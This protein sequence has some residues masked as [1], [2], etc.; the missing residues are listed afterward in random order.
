MISFDATK[1]T[2]NVVSMLGPKPLPKTKYTATMLT[3]NQMVILGGVTTKETVPPFT[4][5]FLPLMDLL[6]FDTNIATW[7]PTNGTG[8]IPADRYSHVAVLGTDGISIIVC[9][10]R[11]SAEETLNDV[12]VLNTQN[13]TWTKPAVVGTPP[14]GRGGLS[15]VFNNGQMII[16]FGIDGNNTEVNEVNVLDTR[17]TPFQW[18]T[19]FSPNASDFSSTTFP[20]NYNSTDT[21]LNNA[22]ASDFAPSDK[23]KA[24]GGFPGVI[25]IGISVLLIVGVIITFLIVRKPWRKR[26]Q[27]K[28]VQDFKNVL[29][30]IP[31]LDSVNMRHIKSSDPYKGRESSGM[32]PIK[33]LPYNSDCQAIQGVNANYQLPQAVPHATYGK[34]VIQPAQPHYKYTNPP[35]QGITYPYPGAYLP[36][37]GHDN[38]FELPT[39]TQPDGTCQPPLNE[40]ETEVRRP[41]ISYGTTSEHLRNP[42]NEAIVTVSEPRNSYGEVPNDSPTLPNEI[43]MAA[44]Q[45]KTNHSAISEGVRNPSNE[46]IVAVSEPRNSYGQAPNDSLMLPNEIDMTARQPKTNHSAIPEG[47]RNPSNEAI[48]AV[49]EPRNSYCQVPN[50][51]LMS[52][53]VDMAARQPK[54]NHGDISEGVGIPLN[55]A[56]VM[57]SQPRNS[58]CQ[59]PDNSPLPPTKWTWDL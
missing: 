30:S 10:G 50:D 22:T 56:T 45:P 47:V 26:A 23:F 4:Y 44:R 59:V 21:N 35:Y 37:I 28:I 3:N 7:I 14:T 54:M 51:S 34:P 25:G 19:G 9:C 39:K 32:P 48:V 55:E 31:P 12:S 8:D 6:V 58:H 2:W 5:T 43:D 52:P 27:P 29:Q 33:L 15:R 17:A 42:P 13:W 20:T 53:N 18:A 57:A 46:A 38:T 1:L 40:V 49:S 16:F 24:V 11:R 41:K 36:G